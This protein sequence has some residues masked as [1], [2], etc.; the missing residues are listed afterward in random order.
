MTDGG[1]TLKFGLAFSGGGSRA[2]AFHLGCM[3]AL[4]DRGIL[5][6]VSVLSSASGGS[7]IAA[8]WAYSNDS[9]E[10][11]DARVVSLLRRGLVGG[12]ARQTLFSMETPRIVGT[13]LTAG[14]LAHVGIILATLARVATAFGVDARAA[15]RF[16]RAVQ[17]PLRRYASR[18]TAFERYLRSIY[19][20]MTVAEVKRQN[21]QTVINAAEL[22]TGTAF[23]FGSAKSGSWRFG[24]ISGEPPLVAKAVAASAA[25][26]LLLPALDEMF[27]FRRADTIERQRVIL[28]DGGVY[29]NIG[30]SCL[31]PG[32]SADYSTNVVETDFIICCDA[33]QG[34]PTGADIPFTFGSRLNASFSTTHRRTHSMSYDLLHRLAAAGEIKGFLLPYLGQIDSKL[35]AAPPNLV[36]R[37]DVFDYPTNFS[38]MADKNIERLTMRGEQLTQTLIDVYHPYL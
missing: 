11:F 8:M 38:P 15:D 28:T 16:A 35:P 33:G 21:L 4:H 7:V 13:V 36:P 9:F 19:G 17:A 32:R 30:V 22:R 25:F 31:L 20:P 2:V 27:E 1:A 26:P 3:R 14:I 29:D 10:D 5:S 6:K 37:A 18:T 23:R 12:I 34:Q 24:E